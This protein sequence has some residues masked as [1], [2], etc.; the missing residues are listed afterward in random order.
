MVVIAFLSNKLTIRGTEVALYD[1]A[2]YN[3]K[4]LGNKS[5]IIT[6]DYEYL[7]QINE[8]NDVDIKVYEKFNKRFRVFYYQNNSDIDNIIIYN[9]VKYLYVI[10]FGTNDGLYS[11]YCKNIIHCVFNLSEP[12]GN[13]YVPIGDFLNR[14]FNT[15][16]TVFPHIVTVADSNDDLR[17]EYNISKNSIVFGRYGGYDTFNIDFVK[18]CIKEICKLR[19]DIYFIFMNTDRFI[20]HKNVYYFEANED[21][22]FKRK[23]INTCNALLHARME[24]ETF[25]LTCGE[26]DICGKFVITYGGS[27]DNEHINILKDKA[28]IYNNEDEL[29]NILMYY[30]DE[31]YM[32]KKGIVAYSKYNAI[33]VMEIFRKL[34]I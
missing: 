18:N 3:E 24:G 29:Y 33:D 21:N 12:H 25:G 23:F 2:H 19:D 13:V 15:N 22:I 26:F 4:I 31:K 9:N 17:Q 32:D 27:Y 28:I 6:R 11:N 7:K 34:L 5:I 16:Y 1:Y 8:M 14:K 20:E 10:K 30:N